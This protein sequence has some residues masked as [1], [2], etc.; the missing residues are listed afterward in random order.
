MAL[1]NIRWNKAGSQPY[2]KIMYY[3]Q[4]STDIKNLK[5]NIS[6]DN[7]GLRTLGAYNKTGFNFSF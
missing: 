3:T 2:C 6:V 7:P 5:I 4:F 1:I